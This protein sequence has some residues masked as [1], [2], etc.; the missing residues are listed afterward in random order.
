VT[1]TTTTTTPAFSFF[2]SEKSKKEGEGQAEKCTVSRK[3]VMTVTID[4]SARPDVR[5]SSLWM[6]VD[7]FLEDPQLGA[8]DLV[9]FATGVAS[10]GVQQEEEDDL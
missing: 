8:K 10:T 6:L 4:S 3:T 1:T 7:H 2:S 5:K 9:T